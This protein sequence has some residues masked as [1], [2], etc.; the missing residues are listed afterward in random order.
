MITPAEREFIANLVMVEDDMGRLKTFYDYAEARGD[1]WTDSKHFTD[2][3]EDIVQAAERQFRSLDIFF[4]D[5]RILKHRN[6]V[7]EPHPEFF[8][9]H[10]AELARRLAHDPRTSIIPVVMYTQR[11]KHPEIE[12]E[13]DDLEENYMDKNVV[14]VHRK[15]PTI[16]ETVYTG[17]RAIR[18]LDVQVRYD[19][20]APPTFT[21]SPGS[22]L[23]VE[24]LEECRFLLNG[25][26]PVN[27]P[28]G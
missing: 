26:P 27:G 25:C 13:L 8:P 5:V 11:S 9:P 28:S 3:V 1:L 10:G 4:L 6:E 2:E 20:D 15:R 17:L 21:V 7:A 19:S 23:R 14:V 22:T 24:D 12:A 16:P 18:R